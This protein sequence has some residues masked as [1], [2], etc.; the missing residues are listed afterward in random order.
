MKWEDT[1]IETGLTIG[2]SRGLRRV[3]FSSSGAIA[4]TRRRGEERRT[5]EKPWTRDEEQTSEGDEE[6]LVGDRNPRTSSEG[7]G[8]NLAEQSEAMALDWTV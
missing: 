7:E 4:T 6:V 5:E 8:S 3:S 1:K 2:K